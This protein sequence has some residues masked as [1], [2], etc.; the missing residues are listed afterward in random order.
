[1]AIQKSDGIIL[2]SQELRQTSLIVNLYTRDFGKI[3]GVF[4]G[5]RGPKAQVG[6][7][8]HLFS[9]NQIIFYERRRTPFYTISG[10]ELLDY[11][12][13]I[14][15][16]YVRVGFASYFLDMVDS[17]TEI[18]DKNKALFELLLNSLKLLCGSSSPRR[19]ARIFEIKLLGL[20][21]IMPEVK[22]C[23]NCNRQI[24]QPR[25]S[26]KLGGLLCSLCRD[27]DITAQAVLLGTVNFIRAVGESSF[28]K[29]IRLKVSEKVGRDVERTLRGFLDYE[30]GRRPKTVD[31]LE[32][33]GA[34]A[35]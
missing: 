17:F 35:R 29:V 19:I 25:F 27:R 31:F 34:C 9:L 16:D 3:K 8:I 30:L 11:F 10:L 26:L 13:P 33:I 21:G 18:G 14:R 32:K 5:V 22:R 12:G 4:K 15:K 20:L 28:D 1:M 7:F 6:T 2:R 24:A 23:L